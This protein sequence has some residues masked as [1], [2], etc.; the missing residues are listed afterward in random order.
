MRKEKREGERWRR[1][2]EGVVRG[3]FWMG[4]GSG[5]G[6]RGFYL[7][8]LFALVGS[9]AAELSGSERIEVDVWRAVN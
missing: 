8:S 1:V 5:E 4:A 2:E 9:A 3:S 7:S 6:Q